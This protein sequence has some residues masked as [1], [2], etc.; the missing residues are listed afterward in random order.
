M[1]TRNP[2]AG[3]T[4]LELLIALWVMAAA[5]LI[6][7]SSLG[8][9][10]RSLARV[11][12]EAADVDRIAAR[13]T[14][15]RWLE[16]MPAAARLTGDASA[17]TFFTLIDSPPLTAAELVEVRVSGDDGAV[18]ARAQAGAVQV[19]LSPA[20]GISSIRYYGAPGVADRSA[21]R[22]DWPV[23]ATALPDLIR[24]DYADGARPMPPLTVI[25]A[26]KA[27]QIEM[28]LSSPV[29]PG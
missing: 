4:L 13:V 17:V 10:G 1:T 23:T 5:A 11:G 20:G 14:L 7:A 15:R 18:R 2:R 16:D 9:M 6:L 8:L 27:G 12:S 24:I 26:R 22:D 29:P 28:S 21:W 25:P 3:V 19:D